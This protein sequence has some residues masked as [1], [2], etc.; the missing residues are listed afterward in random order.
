MD[1]FPTSLTLLLI[2][3]TAPPT[4]AFVLVLHLVLLLALLAVAFGFPSGAGFGLAFGFD[5]G[6]AQFQIFRRD[7]F[8]C[9]P[10]LVGVPARPS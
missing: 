4:F 5:F 8:R 7:A 3:Q 1:G 9:I 2:I 6:P 10:T